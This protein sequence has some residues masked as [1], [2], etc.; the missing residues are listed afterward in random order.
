M[1]AAP[2]GSGL[3]RF[4]RSPT[5]P[6]TTHFWGPI[7][8]WGL[9]IAGFV[10]MYKPPD[11]VSERMTGALCVYSALFMRFA[12]RVQPRNLLLLS[13]HATN[14]TVQLYQLQRCFGGVD[15]FYKPPPGRG[16]GD[17]TRV[18][19]CT[20]ADPLSIYPRCRRHSRTRARGARDCSSLIPLTS[21]PPRHDVGRRRTRP[22]VWGPL[23]LPP[24]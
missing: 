17:G 18:V 1:A 13:C 3:V 22:C 14:E 11:A 4:L 12:W 2:A 16:G 23:L 24:R 7:T 6:M 8:N 15:F 21:P 19:R 9:S 5:G 20:T 10:D